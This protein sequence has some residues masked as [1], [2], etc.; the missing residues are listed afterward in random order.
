MVIV[1]SSIA[2]RLP[3]ISTAGPSRHPIFF[4]A[5]TDTSELATQRKSSYVGD[6]EYIQLHMYRHK[7]LKTS[8]N[9]NGPP[10]SQ[11]CGGLRAVFELVS[12]IGGFGGPCQT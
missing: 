1:T 4:H 10:Q 8:F 5:N 7:F 11:C 12:E 6:C 3:P 9:Q 2:T